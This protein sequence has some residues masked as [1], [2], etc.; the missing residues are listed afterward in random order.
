M[1]RAVGAIVGSRAGRAVTGSV[2]VVGAALAAGLV[3]ERRAIRRR[4]DQPDVAP[5]ARVG[6]IGGRPTT[7]IAADGVPLF[8][9]ETGPADAPLTF[10]FVHGFCVRSDCW[11]LQR[12]EL[13]DLGRMVF[14]D[15]RA[16]GRSGP[17]EAGRCTI[18]VLADDLYRVLCE[19]VPSGPVILVGHSMGGMSVLGLADAHPELFGD[20][21]IGVGLLSTSASELARAALG[22]PA[23]FT[24]AVRRVLP[25][26][27]V[28]MRH[29]SG[30]L[31]RLR[32]GG[33]DLSWEIT[34]R[35]GF[36]ATELPPSI[37]TF[38]EAMVSDTPVEVIGAFLPTLL[39][40]DR[41]AAAGRLA[42]TPTLIVVGDADLITP[43][44][45][46]RAIAA[47]LPDAELVVEPG[48]GHS[49]ML[50]RPEAV[51]AALR[52]LVARALAVHDLPRTSADH[53]LRAVDGTAA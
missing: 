7:V 31:E 43:V 17:S 48:A 36:G 38:L 14:F 41:L 32:G 34:R 33:S 42:A 53:R 15:Q 37:I 24:G 19:R 26:V 45:H 46:S 50:E 4:R 29:A 5:A 6:P 11:V 28:G 27:A 1:V 20:R 13:A 10:V 23:L 47:A 39:D 18:D 35:I 25:G 30:A 22:V 3:A 16:H 52:R 21:I 51:N 8:V 40:N 2:G 44:G 12:R 9:E 49:I